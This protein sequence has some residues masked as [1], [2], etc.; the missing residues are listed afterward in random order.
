MPHEARHWMHNESQITLES[1]IGLMDMPTSS[2]V[3][4]YNKMIHLVSRSPHHW[5]AQ[6][7]HLMSEHA[8]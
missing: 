1:S 7:G 2:S 4:L 6:E 3:M 8:A 5:S